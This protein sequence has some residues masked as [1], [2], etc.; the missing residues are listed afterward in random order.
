[1]PFIK[2]QD[3]IKLESLSQRLK[4]YNLDRSRNGRHN[5]WIIRKDDLKHRLSYILARII[6]E[7]KSSDKSKNKFLEIIEKYNEENCTALILEDFKQEGWIR[8]LTGQALIPRQVLLYVKKVL[9]DKE[10]N[11]ISEKKLNLLK[12][13]N[14]Y[15]EQYFQEDRVFVSKEV[16]EKILIEENSGLSV[17]YFKKEK[18]IWMEKDEKDYV[19]NKRHHHLL[20]LFKNEIGSI[21]WHLI[22][23]KKSYDEKFNQ[24]FEYIRI[25]GLYVGDMR[26]YLPESEC[27]AICKSAHNYLI[28][29]EDLIN[30]EY[31]S[32]KNVFD[33]FERY[34]IKVSYSNDK[35]FRL[36]DENIDAVL[37]NLEIFEWPNRDCCCLYEGPRYIYHT[38]LRLIILNE[39][40]NFSKYDE[41]ISIFKDIS[42]PFLI[43]ALFKTVPEKYP[44]ILPYLL[45]DPDTVPVVLRMV[46]EVVINHNILKKVNHNDMT[47]QYEIKSQIWLEMF[48]FILDKISISN[49]RDK[50]IGNMFARILLDAAEKAFNGR[51]A[52]RF[53]NNR[54]DFY[55]KRY[56]K[57]LYLIENKRIVGSNFNHGLVND[58]I[59]SLSKY[60]INKLDNPSPNHTGLLNLDSGVVD[61]SIK[62]L[63][64]YDSYISGLEES[65][66]K[67]EIE[68]FLKELVASL[69]DYII[70]FYCAKEIS[71]IDCSSGLTK[72]EKVRRRGTG[73][74]G[75]EIIDWGCLFL[76]FQKYD[77]LK[78]IDSDFISSLSFNSDESEYDE[79]NLEQ[80]E[81][82][83]TYLKTLLVAHTSINQ[84]RD[85][86]E[87]HCLPVT[88]TTNE[89]ESLIKYY[90]FNYSRDE[91]SNKRI[92]VFNE[93]FHLSEKNIYH[94]PLIKL[95]YKSLNYFN[96]GNQIEFFKEF[97]LKSV[98]FER[99]LKA[100]NS[101]DSKE[102][103]DVIS[104]RI[105]EIKI[106]DFINS[107]HWITELEHALVEAVN[108]EQHY[109]FA[110]SLIEEVQKH[111]IKR[112][113]V[114]A[115]FNS[116]MFEVKLLLAFKEK[117]WE[118]LYGLE[119]P[120][121]EGG[122]NKFSNEDLKTFYVAIYK[123][124]KDKNYP[125]AVKILK[126]LS[127]KNP[128]D[129]KYSLY[130]YCAQTLEANEK[131]F[132]KE[133][134]A[135]AN[136][137]WD[138]FIKNLNDTE[139]KKKLVGFSE[140]VDSNK[141]FYY[142]SIEDSVSF[143]QTIN[144]LSKRFLYD[145][146]MIPVIYEFYKKREM[147]E[148][149]SNYIKKSE[150]YIREHDKDVSKNVNDL[151]Q[152]SKLERLP[153][154]KDSFKDII[155]QEP[156]NIPRIT[157][158]CINNKK[159]LEVFILNELILAL[160]TLLKKKVATQKILEN[161]YNDF[162]QAVLLPRFAIWGWNINDQPRTGKSDGG[163][164]A[165][166]ADFALSSRGKDFALIEALVFGTEEYNQKHIL[167]CEKYIEY[168]NRYYVIIYYLKK[169]ENFD[170]NWNKY[171]SHVLGIDYPSTFLIDK[172]RGFID[173]TNEFDDVRNFK[174]AKTLHGENAEMFHIMI[175]L[176]N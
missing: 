155:N 56:Q 151:I 11:D 153:I 41:I 123:M 62:L 14:L 73:E 68:K 67:D 69:K 157:P 37:K 148:F 34:E 61:F 64:F 21:L 58:S 120:K 29:E 27:L 112:K 49:S 115:R 82:I 154:L 169:S 143:D 16:I 66:K 145:E 7:L 54:H 18:L 109:A 45:Y 149:A 106:D 116:F 26:N 87:S 2:P 165:G 22:K 175:N 48:E 72:T 74:F 75:Y 23:N 110:K 156:K 80:H 89:L 147:Y 139:E 5:D 108:S 141:V 93:K 173:I 152:N 144:R 129:V 70:R 90:S 4:F 176:G 140:E 95:L 84:S 17:E 111:H 124:Y 137:E 13:L 71:V 134:F 46:D 40:N 86:Y 125:E 101:T 99:M 170:K 138:N 19:W 146:D 55:K 161:H 59:Q 130:L 51:S 6:L 117:D 159:E 121:T 33:C 103:K 164:D 81:K 44:E 92:D 3:S 28:D 53:D 39:S 38:F 168:L 174:I 79:E 122:P 30:S 77:F 12:C 88:K 160:Q 113:T 83:K 118:T 171:E 50:E 100:I 131:E 10:N 162:I 43:W 32:T 136:A 20:N 9:K 102:V 78:K 98:N 119:I 105:K 97:F 104:K 47:E 96:K 132:S 36:K 1:M 135:K 31:E 42:R 35:M 25:S 52:G 107:A 24:F 166:N 85:A 65:E 142:V 150:C 172:K 8:I 167:K 133:M 163:K 126:S 94:T 128:Q 158:E 63:N 76:H 91:L 127:K 114:D 57:A 15:N 60:I